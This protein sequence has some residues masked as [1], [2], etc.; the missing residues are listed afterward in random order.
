MAAGVA[1]G[2][3]TWRFSIQ[4]GDEATHDE[5]VG[6]KG[7][8]ERIRRGLVWLKEH[9]Q[10]VTANLCVNALSYESLPAYAALLTDHGVRQFHVDVVRP[11]NAGVRSEEHLRRILVSCTDLAPSLDAMLRA[12][13]AIDDRYDVN[14][15]NL[16]FCTLPAWAH[17]IQHGGEA[18]ATVT[19]DGAGRLGR[20][21]DKYA[22]QRAGMVYGPRCGECGFRDTCRGVPETYAEFYGL[23]ELVPLSAEARIEADRRRDDLRRVRSDDDDKD[24]RL[25]TA[26]ATRLRAAGPFAGWR[27]GEARRSDRGVRVT[28]RGPNEASF[29]LLLGSRT[30][31]F[32]VEERTTADEARPAI[33]AVAAALRR[34]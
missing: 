6:R 5:V 26:R 14:V 3:F 34:A 2:R 28:F 25:A 11:D 17:R 21:W 23:D 30:A 32:E 13:E 27:W 24:L 15:G 20:V 22:H 10:D 8:F 4:G 16:P 19:T 12:F 7:A 18:T 31:R 9:D 29:A 1:L 33:E